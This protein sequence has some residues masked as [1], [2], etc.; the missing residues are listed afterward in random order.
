MAPVSQLLSTL[1][2]A[3]K[4]T[5]R[6][7]QNHQILRLSPVWLLPE[8]IETP[9]IAPLYSSILASKF[10]TEIRP[11]VDHVLGRSSHLFLDM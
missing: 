10:Y 8:K 7:I 11:Y 2:E 5:A 9:S 3:L 6:Q 4:Q 1:G